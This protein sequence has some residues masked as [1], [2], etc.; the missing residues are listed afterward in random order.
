MVPKLNNL[1]KNQKID[2]ILILFFVLFII[3]GFL[4]M[5][6]I[7]WGDGTYWF[8]DKM[9]EY[10]SI[11]YRSEYSFLNDATLSLHRFPILFLQSFIMLLFNVGFSVTSRLFFYVVPP[12][13][14]VFSSYFLL[15]FFIKERFSKILASLLTLI[16]PYALN[17][18]FGGQVSI[19]GSYCFIPLVLYFFFKSL[20]DSSFIN[21]TL[22]GFFISVIGFY[23]VRVLYIIFLLLLLLS[24]FNIILMKSIKSLKIFLFSSAFFVLLSSFYL[25]PSLFFNNSLPLG[26]NQVGWV[27]S[28]SHYNMFDYFSFN[29]FTNSNSFYFLFFLIVI[30]F[31]FSFFSLKKKNVLILF[32][33]Y[34]I[35]LFLSKG[36]NEPFGFVYIF[37]FENFPF[38][39]AFRDASKFFIICSLLFALFSGFGFEWLFNKK[40]RLTKTFFSLIFV[41]LITFSLPFWSNKIGVAP[42][43]LSSE[44]NEYLLFNEYLSNVS[45]GKFLTMPIRF[46]YWFS[47]QKNPDA[48]VDCD[49]IPYFCNSFFNYGFNGPFF[50]NE[51]TQLGQI[52]SLL[53]IKYVLLHPDSIVYTYIPNFTYDH[54]YYLLSSQVGLEFVNVSGG[55][56][57][58]NDISPL[59]YATNKATV[60]VGTRMDLLKLAKRVNFT[61]RAV[62]FSHDLGD[63]LIDV[64]PFVDS[65]VYSNTNFN[66]LLLDFISD[67]H[68]IL[69]KNK[70]TFNEIYSNSLIN[71][72]GVITENLLEGYPNSIL[73]VNNPYFSGS[74]EVWLRGANSYDGVSGELLV[75][76]QTIIFSFPSTN[77]LNW[78]KVA[79]LNLS[80]NEVIKIN[81]LNKIL[82]DKLVIINSSLINSLRLDLEANLSNI[83]FFDSVDHF[84]LSGDYLTVNYEKISPSYYNLNTSISNSI[85]VFSDNYNQRWGIAGSDNLRAFNSINSFVINNK[86]VVL[87]DKTQI[88]VNIGLLI[89]ISAFLAMFY[90]VIKQVIL[91][92]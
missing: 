75:T 47:N 50:N 57:V 86:S 65:V 9:I 82:I 51:T 88:F 28:L 84:N 77:S 74:Y 42:N 91:K 73:N 8:R 12:I 81:A 80:K 14:C 17:V 18:L 70:G 71:Y 15:D 24:F 56:F 32:L 78:I 87:Y 31:P 66:D 1:K 35:F 37:L 3:N 52:L 49:A 5:D 46:T 89:S 72:E 41:L 30:S 39:S 64:M 60:L 40:K 10:F 55:I 45:D 29:I 58:N 2:L 90:M 7:G 83:H 27:N 22:T 48:W 63:N 6:I 44:P 61:E 54:L 92:K 11:P 76:N 21:I 38:F 68:I 53:N 36:S 34:L 33:V 26:Y 43:M 20:N 85:I 19:L 4:K 79:E 62:Y 13:I 59:F 16:N 23:D 69:S 25:L 67:K